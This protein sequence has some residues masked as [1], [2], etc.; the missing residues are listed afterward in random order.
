MLKIGL[1]FKKFPSFTGKL[2]ENSYKVGMFANPTKHRYFRHSKVSHKNAVIFF[3]IVSVLVIGLA[4]HT[5]ELDTGVEPNPG[6]KSSRKQ[7]CRGVLRKTCSENIQQIYRRTTMPKCAFN[8]VASPV[9]LLHIFRTLFHK[10]T[11]GW[12][13]VSSAKC[14]MSAHCSPLFNHTRTLNGKIS[15]MF[16]HRYFI[17]HCIEL[18]VI[19][20]RFASKKRFNGRAKSNHQPLS[21]NINVN[22]E[23]YRNPMK[24]DLQHYNCRKI[25]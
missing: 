20:S 9:N 24:L 21:G 16:N 22:T 19:P 14:I 7:P 23:I 18:S 1:V 3:I 12:L 8:K 15:P 2:L 5:L 17:S 11:S 10:N 6:P 4:A 25:N 13:L